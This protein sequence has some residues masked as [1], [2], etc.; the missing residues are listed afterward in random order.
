MAVRPPTQHLSTLSKNH[1]KLVQV[2]LYM[3]TEIIRSAI[4]SISGQLIRNWPLYAFVTSNPLAG[5]EDLPFHEAVSRARTIYGTNGYPSSDLFKQALANELLDED[6][7]SQKLSDLDESGDLTDSL[8]EMRSLESELQNTKTLTKLDGHTIKWL[9]AFLDEGTTEWPMP[10]RDRGFYQSWRSLAIYD[11]SLSDPDQI[12]QMPQDAV[13]TLAHLLEDYDENQIQQIIQQHLT[14]LPG[15]T[16]YIL[17]RMEQQTEWQRANP[18]SLEGFLAVRMVL[19]SQ[20]G[21]DLL[22]EEESLDEQKLRRHDELKLAWLSALE[23]SYTEDLK[24]KLQTAAQADASSNQLPDP[25]AQLVFCIDTRSER[26]RR[27]VEQAGSHQTYGYA[28]FFGVAMEYQHSETDVTHKSCPPIVDAQFSV[29]ECERADH[30]EDAQRF[31]RFDHLWRAIK[32]FRFSL[33][34]NVPASFGYVESAGAF[35]GIGLFMRTLLPDT[36]YKMFQKLNEWIP[37]PEHF[38]DLVINNKDE[39]EH[40][41]TESIDTDSISKEE[42]VAMAKNAFQ[43]MGWTDFAPL[44]VF[45]G[46]GSQTAN[47]PFGSSLDCGA[48]AGNRGRHNA[49]VLAQICNEPDVRHRLKAQYDIEIPEVTYFLAGEHNTTTNKI[50]LFDETVPARLQ[51]EL[52]ALHADLDEA[53]HLANSE[54]FK[55]NSKSKNGLKRESHRRAMDWAETRP[56]WGL[57]GNA[58]FIIAPRSLT[59]QLNLGTRAFLHD[60]DW[61]LDPEG[62]ALSAI[63]QG[64]MVVTQWINNHYYFAAVDNKRFGG[65]TKI[66]HHV[67]GSYGVVQG[68]G[69]DLQL[70]LPK[71]SLQEDDRIMQ[72]IPQRLS[73]IIQAPADRVEQIIEAHPESL[74]RLIKNEWLH[75]SIMDPEQDNRILPF[76]PSAV[77]SEDRREA[78]LEF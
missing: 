15:W 71:E 11:Y 13:E 24:S 34:N 10:N 1:P 72:H 23:E 44:V 7:I 5:F 76:Q 32:G 35:Y 68:N 57:A 25:D 17:Y 8:E 46:H 3:N 27:A 61:Q 16:G 14:A 70:G 60:Y 59:R 33:K 52:K 30:Q 37:Q 73:V 18:I 22:S 19:A 49:R 47:N 29:H 2:L 62:E 20:L 58:S 67:T 26:I 39:H 75:L 74:G 56:E 55:L 53:C 51:N 54:Q 64:P 42:K 45:V 66:T 28:G 65:G 41:H 48:C 78:V 77:K 40:I 43:L 38:S 4:Q 6:R 31:R 63:L 12:T 36:V 21:F 69:G 50:L 9:S